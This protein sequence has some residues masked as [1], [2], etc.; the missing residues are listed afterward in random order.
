MHV[1]LWNY[2]MFRLL[3]NVDGNDERMDAMLVHAKPLRGYRDGAYI[4]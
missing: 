4:C 3:V 2:N 1:W